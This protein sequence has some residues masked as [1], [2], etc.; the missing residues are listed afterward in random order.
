RYGLSSKEFTPAMVQGVFANLALETPKNHFTVGIVDDV[1]HTSLAYDSEF[2]IEPDRVVRSVFYGLGSDGTVGA[3]KNSIKII[4]EDTPNYA[5]GYFVYDS[6]KSGSVTVS[7]LRFGPE[8]IRSTYLISRANFIA[9]HQWEFVQKLDLLQEAQPGATLLLNSPYDDPA[10]TWQRLPQA[11]QQQIIDKNIQVY[12]INAYPVARQA[13]MGSR[14]NTVMQVCFFALAGVLPR[15]EAIAAIKQAIRKTYGK[16]GEEV[17]A[18]N[19][20]A[21]DSSLDHLHPVPVGPP[22]GDDQ[23]HRWVPDTAP[24]FVQEVLGK[25]MA[26]DGDSLPVS[27]LP[28]DGTYPCGTS[29]Y[30]KRNVAQEVPL[31]DP[32]VCV[33]CGKCVMVCPHAVI[34]SKVYEESAL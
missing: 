8:P 7:H 17:V 24:A 29:Q 12:A 13:G 3:N 28:A 23:P 33:Q 5:Q 2:S 26:R 15:E 9:C 4:G 34:R 6:K 16:K 14:I 31:W 30:E 10:E 11:I 19:I 20:Q 21:V 27:A 25:I 32:D 22:S 1:S 18:M